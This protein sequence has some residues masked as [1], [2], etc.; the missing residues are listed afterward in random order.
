ME[1]RNQKQ[2][3]KTNQQQ[4]QQQNQSQQQGQKHRHRA[5]PIFRAGGQGD[6]AAQ[7]GYPCGHKNIKEGDNPEVGTGKAHILS[8]LAFEP[9][10]VNTHV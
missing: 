1:N 3:Q 10:A 8:G 5:G 4:N 9:S 2:N 6:E 7:D